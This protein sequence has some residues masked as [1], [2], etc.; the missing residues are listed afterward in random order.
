VHT[1]EAAEAPRLPSAPDSFPGGRLL[2]YLATPAV[3]SQG[4]RPDLADTGATLV[5]AAVG[6]PEVIASARPHRATGRVGNAQLMS[7]APAG[8]VYFLQFPEPDAG[9][10]A[11]EYAR[12]QHGR[13]LVQTVDVLATAGFGLALA[14]R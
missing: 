8:S 14:G 11:A 9:R 2:L 13:A 6:G 5:G 1:C 7:A 3:F 12:R 10:A 4:W